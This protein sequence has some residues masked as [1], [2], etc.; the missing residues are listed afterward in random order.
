MEGYSKV[1]TVAQIAPGRMHVF[2]V[3][4]VR[5]ALANL[6]GRICAIEDICTHDDGPLGEGELRDHVIECPRHGATFDVRT[7]AVLS[8]PAVTPV[9]SFETRVEGGDVYVKIG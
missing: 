9:R 3:E 1:A 7:G 2:R 8:M 6:G 5:I 4:G